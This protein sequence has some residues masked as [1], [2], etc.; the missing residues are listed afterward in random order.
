M[1][2]AGRFGRGLLFFCLF[3]L[4]LYFVV[5]LR[6]IYHGGGMVLNFPVFYRGWEFFREHLSYPGGPV[7]YVSA[8]FAQFFSIGWAGALAATAQAFLMCVCSWSIIKA[9]SGKKAGWVGYI[10]A[11]L[12][13][14]VYSRYSYQFGAVMVLLASLCFVCLYL[15][16]VNK[17]SRLSFL[18]FLVMS[19]VVYMAGGESYIWFVILCAMYEILARRRRLAG[20]IYLVS[21]A[22]AGQALGSLVFRISYCESIDYFRVFRAENSILIIT[23][24]C[25]LY[26]FVPVSVL[27]LRFFVFLSSREALSLKDKVW[28]GFFLNIGGIFCWLVPFVIGASA[29]VFLHDEQRKT[30]IEVDY[31]ACRRMWPEVLEA[32]KRYPRVGLI[33][34]TVNRALYHQGRLADDMFEYPQHKDAL[35]LSEE[36]GSAAYWKGFDIYFDL[37][38]MN[39]SEYCLVV[40]M[41]MYGELPIILKRLA[42]VNILK[43]NNDAARVYLKKLEKTLFDAEWAR[44]WLEKIEKDPDMSQ[45]IDVLRLRGKMGL[46][47]KSY[48]SITVQILPELSKWNKRNRMAYQYMM[49]YYLM[50]SQFNDF[51]ANLY[52]MREYRYTRVPLSYEEAILICAEILLKTKELDGIDVSDESRRRFGRFV[53][54]LIGK[55]KGNKDAAFEELSR[56]FGD[57]YLFYSVYERSGISK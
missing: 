22:I 38:Q 44:T 26:L 3:Y 23:L 27:A 8:F 5:D 47:D 45:E 49:A 30:V 1:D 35:I 43:R 7:D 33:C 13:L 56:D 29:V 34:H 57:T 12:I 20:L 46:I 31:Y 51:L 11:I 19:L 54:I 41:E 55:Y 10:P 24:L 32:A 15:W 9:I 2:K 25:I 28:R 42:F 16:I 40:S 53:R 21:G 6:L 14:T 36:A 18:L 50:N 17:T 52:R 4:Y 37:G 48:S 39:L